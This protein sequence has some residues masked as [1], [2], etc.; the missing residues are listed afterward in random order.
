MSELNAE[1]S[2]ENKIRHFRDK[3]DHNKKEALRGFKFVM[4][5]TV[6]VP[7]LIAF[8]AGDIWSKYVPASLSSLGAFV[9]A[10]LQ[11]RKPNQLWSLY[12]TAERN[13]EYHLELYRFNAGEYKNCNDKEANFIENTNIICLNTNSSW[14]ELVPSEKELSKLKQKKGQ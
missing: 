10:W 11:L 14:V 4:F 9:T 2:V 1:K 3:A 6:A 8:G 12:R 7:L 13:L 5:S